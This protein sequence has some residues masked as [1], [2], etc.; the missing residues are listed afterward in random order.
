MKGR[1]KFFIN[2][3]EKESG[4]IIEFI[5][6]KLDKD[7]K[8]EITQ[9]HTE[10][11]KNNQVDNW[12]NSQKTLRDKIIKEINKIILQTDFAQIE[13][14]RD[15][16]V[17]KDY[18][19]PQKFRAKELSTIESFLVFPAARPYIVDRNVKPLELYYPHIFL[20]TKDKDLP[21]FSRHD[22]IQYYQEKNIVPTALSDLY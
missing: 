9:T 20:H 13:A 11:S 16:L 5:R 19:H 6:F 18:Q 17:N 21:E 15:K 10:I 1:F 12:S 2:W 4:P 8:H 7:L 22:L 14:I 3:L